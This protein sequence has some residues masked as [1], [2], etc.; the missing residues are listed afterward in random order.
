MAPATTAAAPGRTSP[1]SRSEDHR[2]HQGEHLLRPDHRQQDRP[3]DAVRVARARHGRLA[4]GRRLRL[5]LFLRLHQQPGVAQRD[6]AAAADSRPARAVRAAVRHR[7]RAQPRGDRPARALP[8]Q[9]PR[10]RHRATPRSCRP[11]SARPTSASSTSTCRRF[12]KSNGSSRRPRR[13]ASPST[14][15]WT[16][17]T[18]CRPT[19]PSTSS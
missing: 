19:S 11:R 3:R 15:A 9:H 6:A 5:G 2:R 4:P 12:A 8:P 17:R 13:R 16:S 10:L 7:R 14:P 1:A 18:A